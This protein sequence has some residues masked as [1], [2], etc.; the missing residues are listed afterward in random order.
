MQKALRI[1]PIALCCLLLLASCGKTDKSTRYISK[2]AIGVISVNSGQLLK[3]VGLDMILSGQLFKE[4]L[5]SGKDSTAPNLDEMG[6]QY[7]STAYAYAVPDQRLSGK[8]R[9]MLI[10]PLKDAAKFTAL[11]KKQF[12]DAKIST[13][14]E[15]TLAASDNIC[16]GW[17]KNTAIIAFTPPSNEWADMDKGA[18][19]GTDA[20]VVLSEEV[21][22]TFTMPE[23][24]SMVSN[25]KFADLLK[26]GHDISF[27]LNYENLM[28][29][30]PQEQI[31]QAGTI[32]ASQKKLLKDAYV[33]GGVNFEN[34]K[35]TGDA[36]YYFNSSVKAIANALEAKSAND[37]LLKKVQ[38][39]QLNLLM[40]YHINPMGIKTMLDTMG[41]SSFAALAL[42]E[43]GLT[44]DEVLNAF[45]GDFLLAVTDFSVATESQSYTMGGSSV[46]YTKPVPSYKATLSFKLKDKASFDKLLQLA[47]TNQVLTSTAP[48]T[49]SAGF[50]HLIT[51]G[52]Y[53]ALSDQP[54]VATAYLQA[55]GNN[56]FKVPSDVK[57]S[58]FGFFM[59]IRNSIQAVPLDLLYGKQDTALF[60]DGRNLLENIS[61]HGG[62]VKDDHSDFHF[63]A[64][65][66]NKEKNSLLQIIDFAKKVAEAEKKEGDSFDDVVPATDSTEE[67]VM[68]DTAAPA[69]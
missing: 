10:L 39:K 18:T 7:L 68:A 50:L 62:K 12:A 64:T 31:G 61:A 27:W 29:S 69:I 1:I 21:Q 30:L 58:P 49:Y 34:G 16:I 52:D 43:Y 32:M 6:I 33:A 13:K 36:T 65:F 2:D 53:V 51:N 42:K 28:N 67:A 19:P 57:N 22:K 46:N 40:S 20:A 3:K 55:S 8:S 63:E 47:I 9:F 54:A 45:S 66:V 14:D 24:Q 56:D 4:F 41:V 35:I 60:H 25:K 38:G 17:D 26:A 15:L 37:D 48:N 23:D 59:D 44:L 5:K 11:V